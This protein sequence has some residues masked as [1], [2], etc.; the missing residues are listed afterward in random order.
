MNFTIAITGPTKSGKSAFIERHKSGQFIVN[1]EPTLLKH[2]DQTTILKNPFCTL[3][4]N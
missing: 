4:D 2:T 3:R 1:H